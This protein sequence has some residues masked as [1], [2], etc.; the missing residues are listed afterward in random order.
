[1]Q[2]TRDDLR[3]IDAILRALNKLRFDV[4]GVEC[5][6]LAGDLAHFGQLRSRVEVD[7]TR[8]EEAYDARVKA[9]LEASATVTEAP[10]GGA[11]TEAPPPAPATTRRGRK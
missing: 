10:Q 1:M 3:C 2:V 6:Q 11:P 4:N 7:V 5:M 8:A 9:A